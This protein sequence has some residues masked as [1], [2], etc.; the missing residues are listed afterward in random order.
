VLYRFRYFFGGLL[1]IACLPILSVSLSFIEPSQA[2]ASGSSRAQTAITYNDDPNLVAAGF[3]A[4]MDKL[5]QTA[6]AAATAIQSANHSFDAAALSAVKTIGDG[7]KLIARGAYTGASWTTHGVSEGVSFAASGPG[8]VWRGVS[9]AAHI[10]SF[11]S[12]SETDKT[13]IPQIDPGIAAEIA[14]SKPILS[15]LP[16]SPKGVTP[17]WPIHGIITEEFGVPHMPYQPIHT[18]IDISDA[19][20]PGVTPI[21]P[22]KPGRVIAVVH[23]YSGFGNHV[24]VDHGGGLL[25]LYGHMYSTA[26]R[27]GQM[28]DEN[29]TLGLEGST[30]VS[31]GVHVHFEIDLNGQPVDP[32]RYV[33]GQP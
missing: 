7:G 26:V 19:A 23:S 6:T 15:T 17:Q 4:A 3:A 14:N 22:F 20:A 8:Y 11:I 29:T 27:V 13:P 31:T 9:S 2:Q 24:I 32:H 5:S 1:L 25:S 10:G 30:G 16:A 12:P 28:V 21:K 33:A 18:G